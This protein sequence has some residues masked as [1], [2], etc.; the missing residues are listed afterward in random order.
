MEYGRI[1]KKK[2][3]E[4]T[5]IRK[6]AD[7]KFKEDLFK[8][9]TLLSKISLSETRN[10]E[11]SAQESTM[12]KVIMINNME[13][14]LFKQNF[15][16]FEKIRAKIFWDHRNNKGSGDPFEKKIEFCVIGTHHQ[17]DLVEQMFL[18]ITQ[19]VN[20]VK[21]EIGIVEAQIA[22]PALFLKKLI[23]NNHQNL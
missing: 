18:F 17:I 20:Q 7:D 5:Q 11:E 12:K 6:I 23:G 10:Q 9:P 2:K 16:L 8:N 19:T 21:K 15:V 1:F 4:I 22:M 13:L 3:E 14:F